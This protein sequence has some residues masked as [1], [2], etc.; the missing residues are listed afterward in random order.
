M[1]VRFGAWTFFWICSGTRA[2]ISVNFI[3]FDFTMHTSSAADF[4]WPRNKKLRVFYPLNARRK[5]FWRL[6]VLTL[7]FTAGWTKVSHIHWIE[8]VAGFSG[9]GTTEESKMIHLGE[10]ML[11][12]MI[13]SRKSAQAF[14]IPLIL[15]FF[16]PLSSCS[17]L[18]VS[19]QCHRLTD[20]GVQSYSVN[21]SSCVGT[22]TIIPH[23]QIITSHFGR[24][25]EQM[26]IRMNNWHNWSI[27]LYIYC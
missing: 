27:T 13:F 12:K 20:A 19:H 3:Y 11:K 9:K 5:A 26:N 16:F 4:Q 23:G 7:Q 15:T 22:E 2:N 18:Q 17:C 24:V 6:L 1:D 10:E 14:S 25:K 8:D 21:E